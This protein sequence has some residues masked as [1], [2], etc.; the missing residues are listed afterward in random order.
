MIELHNEQLISNT[1]GSNNAQRIYC[2]RASIIVVLKATKHQLPAFPELATE[3]PL[4]NYIRHM[5]LAMGDT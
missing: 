4:Q 2:P 3:T 1:F 5:T